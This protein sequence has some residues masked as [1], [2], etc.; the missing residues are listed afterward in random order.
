MLQDEGDVA[1]RVQ[2]RNEL[3]VMLQ[4]VIGQFLELRGRKRLRLDQRGRGSELEM[5]FELQG[6]AVHLE[7]RRLPNGLLQS[8]HAIEMMRVIPIQLAELKVGPIFNLA[9]GQEQHAVAWL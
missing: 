1:R 8:F 3:D 4:T 6:E 7:K 2:I 5:A 9:F